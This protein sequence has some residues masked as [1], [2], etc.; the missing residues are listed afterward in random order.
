MLRIDE[1]HLQHLFCGPC[2]FFCRKK[3]KIQAP[4]TRA[5]EYQ[6][7]T[8]YTG[9]V[10]PAELLAFARTLNGIPY[11]Y[12]SIDPE[13]GFD[14]SGFITYVFNHFGI[15]VPRRSVDFTYIDREVSIEDARPG[16]LILFTGSDSTLR[17]VGHM[18]IVVSNDDNQLTFIHSTSG[19]SY[20]IT[21]TPLNSYYQAR[22]VKTIRIFPQNDH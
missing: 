1:G 17:I 21:E 13:Q 4:V 15:T 16:D 11:K 6:V 14:C 9:N 3:E 20:G 10:T 19:K 12:G 7:N 18:G 8:I 2:F 22:Y 5:S